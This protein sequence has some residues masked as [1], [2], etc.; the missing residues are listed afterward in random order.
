[1]TATEKWQPYPWT[2][3]NSSI[4]FWLWA[5]FF[6]ILYASQ[7]DQDWAKM[8]PPCCK[9]HV[10]LLGSTAFWTTAKEKKR[11]RGGVFGINLPVVGFV[12]SQQGS[13]F[14]SRLLMSQMLSR[15]NS[16]CFQAWLRNMCLCEVLKF[17]YGKTMCISGWEVS[18]RRPKGDTWLQSLS[19]EQ[20]ICAA[21][22][23][24]DQ[25]RTKQINLVG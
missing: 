25:I 1:M 21:L 19:G 2:N 6:E 11:R 16:E 24:V 22:E 10:T 12:R 4:T 5:I 17:W 14:S 13:D 3:G 9:W 7:S 20:Q 15:V 8:P 18:Q 23:K